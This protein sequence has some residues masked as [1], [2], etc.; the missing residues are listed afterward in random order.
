VAILALAEDPE[1]NPRKPIKIPNRL[2]DTDHLDVETLCPIL[3]ANPG[4]KLGVVQTSLSAECGRYC[5]PRNQRSM[6]F[7]TPFTEKGICIFRP[8]PADA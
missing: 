8:S 2:H 5:G 7:C 4:L 3:A 6:G 1:I